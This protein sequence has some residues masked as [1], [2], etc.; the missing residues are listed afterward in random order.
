ML[1]LCGTLAKL[2]SLGSP[3][4][5]AIA[6]VALIGCHVCEAECRKGAEDHAPCK[7]CA[8]AYAACAAGCETM[9]D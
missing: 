5:P 6:K 3:Y 9:G 4:L 7:A 1:T 2:A 8:E